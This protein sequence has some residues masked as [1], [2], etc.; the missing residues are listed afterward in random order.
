MSKITSRVRKAVM[1]NPSILRRRQGTTSRKGAQCL[2]PM[3]IAD[4]YVTVEGSVHS[5][6]PP[7]LE[8]LAARQ[9]SSCYRKE[10]FPDA[11]NISRL[12]SP[13]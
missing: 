8:T 5:S 12:D 1:E 13:S 2:I 10:G 9:T 3:A 6:K 4:Q 11:F 7:G